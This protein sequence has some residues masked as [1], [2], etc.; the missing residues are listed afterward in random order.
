[1]GCVWPSTDG[2][3]RQPRRVRFG[4]RLAIHDGTTDSSGHPPSRRLRHALGSR[5]ARPE[6][7]TPP[8]FAGDESVPERSH[9]SVGTA[10]DSA[11][12][13]VWAAIVGDRSLRLQ[14]AAPSLDQ[15]A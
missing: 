3:L 8:T 1:T 15:L 7:R 10:C 13:I 4:D 12:E 6:E 9:T 14:L 5:E 2:S 11:G